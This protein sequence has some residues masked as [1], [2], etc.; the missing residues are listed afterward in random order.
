MVRNYSH[1][2]LSGLPKR[3]IS[4]EDPLVLDQDLRGLPWAPS[5]LPWPVLPSMQ[6]LPAVSLPLS[7]LS[8]TPFWE[9]SFTER[10]GALTTSYKSSSIAKRLL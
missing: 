10:H 3:G 2:F 6:D 4:E 9:G 1:L 5:S 8:L 7:V